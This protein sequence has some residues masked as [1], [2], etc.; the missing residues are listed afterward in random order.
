MSLSSLKAALR[1]IGDALPTS[2]VEL[3]LI[4]MADAY[5]SLKMAAS[6]HTKSGDDVQAAELEAL[7]NKFLTTR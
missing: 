4:E 2:T 5:A 1:E 6:V 7:A 3:N